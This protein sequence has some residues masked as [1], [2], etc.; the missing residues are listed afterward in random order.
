MRNQLSMAM[1][2]IDRS[3]FKKYPVVEK[4]FQKFEARQAEVTKTMDVLEAKAIVY[5]EATE[6]FELLLLGATRPMDMVVYLNWILD[7][8]G[9]SLIGDDRFLGVAAKSK[10]ILMI[11]SRE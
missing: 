10:E 9:A 7:P 11:T 6:L 1:S 4:A 5:R 8:T 2:Y 3:Y